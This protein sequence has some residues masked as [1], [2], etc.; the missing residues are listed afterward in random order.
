[1][2]LNRCSFEGEVCQFFSRTSPP[3]RDCYCKVM[4]RTMSKWGDGPP[5]WCPFKMESGRAMK[6]LIDMTLR[7]FD[8]NPKAILKVFGEDVT[9][10]LG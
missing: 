3:D 5:S 7:H 4:R 2:G 9:D 1:M 6:R 8:K 10:V